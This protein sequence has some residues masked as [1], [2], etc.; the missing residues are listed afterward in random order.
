ML[1]KKITNIWLAT[2]AT[3]VAYTFFKNSAGPDIETLDRVV[4]AMIWF[5][6]YSLVGF[7]VHSTRCFAPIVIAW[8]VVLIGILTVSTE[9]GCGRGPNCGWM[10][11]VCMVTTLL[12]ALVAALLSTRT[13]L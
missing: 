1:V 2:I 6:P 13:R 11:A 9:W 4:N 7:V 10:M 3:A 5:V 8:C 12:G